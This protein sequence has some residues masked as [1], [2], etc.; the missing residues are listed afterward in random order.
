MK[1]ILIPYLLHMIHVKEK[2]NLNVWRL[3]KCLTCLNLNLNLKNPLKFE[4]P[5]KTYYKFLVFPHVTSR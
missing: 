4:N 1:E 3:S 5:N 2:G